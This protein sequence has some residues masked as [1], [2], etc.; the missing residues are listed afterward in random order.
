ML[1]EAIQESVYV[2]KG[3]YH[4]QA[5]TRPFSPGRVRYDLA[6]KFLLNI[7]NL[8]CLDYG[9]GDA[10]MA[11]LMADRGASVVVFDR[12]FTALNYAQKDS[13]LKLTQGATLLPFKDNSFDIVTML[14][15][16]EHIPDKEELIALSEVNRVMV[17]KGFLIISVPSN[18]QEVINK[19][20][21]HYNPAD[22]ERK[23]EGRR[24]NP[25]NLVS[26]KERTQWRGKQLPRPVKGLIY[27]T[28]WL[29][30]KLVNWSPFIKCRPEEADS[31]LILAQKA[32]DI[33]SSESIKQS[34]LTVAA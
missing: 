3:D 14:D 16:I 25:L 24:F 1:Q 6:T 32:A 21:R 13:R 29:F 22:L 9:G 4:R 12:S 33:R 11:T 17:P 28:D 31:F 27:G 15:V 19:H 8:R 7:R 20:Y 5:L 34:A 30:G 2:Q 26:Y 10:A 18:R 23:L